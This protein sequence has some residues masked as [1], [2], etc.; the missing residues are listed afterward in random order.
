MVSLG[1][2]VLT[3]WRIMLVV[4]WTLARLNLLE[5]RLKYI[6]ICYNFWTLETV[7]IIE[8]LHCERW[9]C[10]FSTES[11]AWLLMTWW[12]KG[13][14]HQLLLYWIS[15]S[16]FSCRGV[17]LLWLQWNESNEMLVFRPLLYLMTL[18]WTRHS[19]RQWKECMKL[20]PVLDR[21][22]IKLRV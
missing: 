4:Y 15:Y 12:Y 17:L 14:G 1:S 19:L 9:G 8:I 6:C 21:S 10:V 22:S 3:E 5:K 13:P 11:I 20:P 7:Q 16:V 2:N 18:N